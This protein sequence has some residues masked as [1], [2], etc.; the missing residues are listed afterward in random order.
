MWSWWDSL[1]AEERF[2]FWMFIVLSIGLVLGAVGTISTRLAGRQIDRLKAQ[3]DAGQQAEIRQQVIEAQQRQASAEQ[4]VRALQ[5]RVLTPEQKT[6]LIT[7]LSEKHDQSVGFVSRMMDGE[8][9][10]YAETLAAIFRE[11]GWQVAPINRTGLYDLPN[12]LTLAV[13]VENPDNLE[14]VAKS[15]H[16]DPVADFICQTLQEV[17]INCQPA[18]IPPN[19]YSGPLQPHTLYIFVGRKR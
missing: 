17:G 16:L 19:S 4:Q 8:S 10:D 3:R 2:S 14:S 5:P 18:S 13:I 11:A 7:Q 9:Q 1:E 12:M 15:R 6:L